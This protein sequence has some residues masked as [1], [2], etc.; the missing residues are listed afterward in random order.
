MPAPALD[1]TTSVRGDFE[2]QVGDCSK[3]IKTLMY[4]KYIRGLA[5]G[6]SV[7]LFAFGGA[8]WPLT[9][10]HSDP[11]WTRTWFGCVNGAPG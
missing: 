5:Q 4:E 2:K 1:L 10:A 11:L 3:L 9:T 7:R 6:L 8:S